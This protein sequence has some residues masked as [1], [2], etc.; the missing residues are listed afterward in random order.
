MK[1]FK[2]IMEETADLA[3]ENGHFHVTPTKN[4][5]SILKHGLVPSVG[6]RS[7]QLGEHPSVFLFKDKNSAHD[8]VSNWLGD[9]FEEDEPLSLLKV[10][11]PKHL[12]SKET[13]AG[14]EKQVFD[15]IHPKHISLEPD[16][17]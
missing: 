1:T 6:D 8:A 9:Q 7:K 15:I 3:D 11:L 5:D 2:Q 4:V 10:K 17:L 16:E 12:N 13:S 14:Y